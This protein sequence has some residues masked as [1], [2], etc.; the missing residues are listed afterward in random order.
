[1]YICVYIIIHI[2]LYNYTLYVLKIADLWPRNKGFPYFYP[3]C[4]QKGMRK[5][6]LEPVLSILNLL[7]QS[8]CVLYTREASPCILIGH[9][10]WLT[11]TSYIGASQLSSCLWNLLNNPHPVT[12]ID[13]GW[14][15]GPMLTWQMLQG[16]QV[17]LILT[18]HCNELS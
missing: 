8:S 3:V 6:D 18:T 2:K 15:T 13:V 12:E 7:F 5:P 4:L 17:T 10:I 16:I 1:M 14:D 9:E 11:S